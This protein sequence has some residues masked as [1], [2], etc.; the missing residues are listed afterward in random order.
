MPSLT[1]IVG[2][3]GNDA[4]TAV[5]PGQAPTSKVWRATTKSTG[6]AFDDSLYGGGRPAMSWMGGGGN[7]LLVGG[8]GADQVHRRNRH[9]YGELLWVVFR[10]RSQSRDRSRGPAATLQATR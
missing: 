1:H 2:T 4:L 6:G 3:N 10:R 9:R 7:D 5:L 8:E